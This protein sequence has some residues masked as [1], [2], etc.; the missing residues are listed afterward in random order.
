MNVSASPPIEV[1]IGV[2][3]GNVVAGRMGSRDRLIYSVIGSRVNLAARLCSHALE[4][5]VIVDQETLKR[6]GPGAKA[7][8]LG[9][10]S[11]KGF[12]A[13]VPVFELLAIERAP[14]SIAK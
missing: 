2:A 5:Q 8:A 9:E 12:S 10:V 11:L 7:R 3:S 13:A 14:V 4:R 6:I 1:S